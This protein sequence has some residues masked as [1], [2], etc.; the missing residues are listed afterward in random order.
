MGIATKGITE[1]WQKEL[2]DFNV[3][4]RKYLRYPESELII[5]QMGLN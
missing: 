4:R 1:T 3:I 2:R 5:Q